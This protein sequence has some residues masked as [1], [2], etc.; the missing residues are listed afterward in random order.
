MRLRRKLLEKS[1]LYLI[2][3]KDV[4]KRS[5]LD[6][7]RKLAK[8]GVDMI[9]LRD[10][11]SFPEVLLEEAILL[12]Q[13]LKNTPTLFIVNDNPD[14]AKLSGSD[15][16]HIGQKDIPIQEAR[17]LL[18]RN[19][20]IGVSCSNLKQALKAQKEGADYIGIGPIFKT[21]T[22]RDCQP[23]GLKGL[24]GLSQRI[25]IPVFAIG[26]INRINLK[27][28]VASGINRIALCRAILSSKDSFRSASFFA[29]KLKEI[30]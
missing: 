18:G 1:R 17:R 19:K 6:T 16:L 24:S 2:L 26:N 21:K 3:D 8:S 25:K 22:K 27:K 5:V 11:S 12:N 29:T 15:G 28:I 30:K 10:K 23:I 4:F 13:E 20:I 9:Q 7:A 14:I